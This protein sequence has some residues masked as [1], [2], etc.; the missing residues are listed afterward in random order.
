[1]GMA[2]S[3]LIDWRNA[4]N[5]IALAPAA[6]RGPPGA[7]GL[8]ARLL[9]L[10]ARRGTLFLAVGVFA[11]L[12]W[13]ALA[14]RLAPLLVPAVFALITTAFLRL[15]W[16]ETAAFGR[17]PGL[18]LGAN[19]W[20]LLLSPLLM[21]AV[22]AVTGP[23]PALATALVL[24]AAAPPI[25]SSIAFALLLELDAALAVTATFSA[26][27]LVPLTLPPV[28]LALLGLEL[29]IDVGEFMLR[30]ALLVGG[31][32]V[33]A[34]VIR[35]LMGPRML[36]ARAAEIDGVTVLLLVVFAIAIMDGVTE[37]AIA[38]PGFVALT[39][40]A[41]FL[42]NLGL[43]AA[44]ALVFA[45]LGRRR[46][47]TFGLVSGNRNMGLLL[48]ALAGAAERDVMLYFAIGQ[49]PMDVLPALLAPLYRRLM[50]AGRD[51]A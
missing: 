44:G 12:A 45:G 26:T 24:M 19:L 49:I 38:R 46:A 35:R 30:L 4:A 27:F 34:A 3:T 15:D 51:A 6:G 29:E 16:R 36:A 28:A 25:M 1:M 8:I 9:R 31:A 47:L 11:G 7:H 20:L 18:A 40:A 41:A 32:L 14:A 17:R 5:P 13:P 50:R 22:V 23:P 21:T 10:L 39:T 43:L 48:A 42:A 33:A 2:A 37:T